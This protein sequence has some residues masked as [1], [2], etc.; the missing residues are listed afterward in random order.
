M[1]WQYLQRVIPNIA[2]H[3]APVEEA[4][5]ETF[6]PALFQTDK[7]TVASIRKLVALSVRF[8]GLGIP[9]PTASA[10]VCHDASRTCTSGLTQS[11][12]E[13]KDLDVVVY[14][15]RIRTARI[16]VKADRHAWGTKALETIQADASARDARRMTRAMETGGWLTTLP[17]H[18]NGTALSEEE[19]RDSLRLRMGL[20]PLNLPPKC[21][22]C[23]SHFTVDHALTCKKGGLILMRHNDVAAEWHELCARALTPSSVSDEPL[24]YS[25]RDRTAERSG[26]ATIDPELR[27]DVGCHG[28]WKKATTTIFDVRI[29]DTDAPAYRGQDPAMVLLGHEKRKKDKYNDACLARRRTFTPLVFSVDG[30]RGPEA[31]A[32]SKRLASLLAT[33]WKRTYSDVCGF[34]RSRLSIA[35]VRTT[36]LCLRGARDPTARRQT[37]SWESGTGLG[38]YR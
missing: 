29:T 25:G 38:L 1:E 37:V 23:R 6:L 17:N 14:A 7:A 35:L 22:G 33:K 10:P 20:T 31:T 5:S 34:V 16:Q 8:A 32:A 28:F 4:I 18:L 27:G 9:D 21:D 3:F 24:I 19:S 2:H 36:S 15:K 13:G 30:M 12:L 26:G 11:L